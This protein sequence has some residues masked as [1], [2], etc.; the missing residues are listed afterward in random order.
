MPRQ[1]II[2]RKFQCAHCDK[3][4]SYQSGL[5]IHMKDKH[6]E[7]YNEKKS[8]AKNVT[9]RLKPKE[10]EDLDV[11]VDFMLKF[12]MAFNK[13]IFGSSIISK[14]F[15][16]ERPLKETI[17]V[18]LVSILNNK[19][20]VD[21]VVLFSSKGSWLVNDQLFIKLTTNFIIAL[22]GYAYMRINEFSPTKRE[23]LGSLRDCE[24]KLIDIMKHISE[25]YGHL[26]ENYN[27]PA[28]MT[29]TNDHLFLSTV[30]DVRRVFDKSINRKDPNLNDGSTN[31][32]L[33]SA[34]DSKTD[35]QST[36]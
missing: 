22:E 29:E 9:I 32:S 11:D 34:E 24:P 2:E 36:S 28:S 27:G 20:W 17:P 31:V 15:A 5:C 3:A 1:N 23:C 6:P 10:S 12:P 21:G 30:N 8:T 26:Y 4:Y 13:I 7:V 18:A 16:S 19:C 25:F 35:L 14:M 33:K